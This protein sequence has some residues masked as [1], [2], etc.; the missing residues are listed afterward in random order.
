MSWRDFLHYLF[1][2]FFCVATITLCWL[3]N[4]EENKSL[5]IFAG[6]VFVWGSTTG[7]MF[8]SYGI[9][10]QKRWAVKIESMFKRKCEP[11]AEQKQ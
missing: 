3:I 6:M 4:E 7:V 5:I 11:K 10:N 8:Y 9:T 2:V 1:Y